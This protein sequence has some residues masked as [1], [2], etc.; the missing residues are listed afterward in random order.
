M[1]VTKLMTTRVVTVDIDS[2]LAAIKEIYDNVAF[3]HLLVVENHLLCGVIS[4][5]DVLKVLSP[6][7]GSDFATERDLACLK[8][9]AHQIMSRHLI[10]LPLH[11]DIQE[12]IHI[13]NHNGVSCIPIIDATRHPVG[14]LTWRDIMRA[15]EKKKK[16][17]VDAT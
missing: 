4:D 2:D 16:K 17:P 10:T 9:K 12:A 1:T 11:A 13:F 7:V 8:K 15:L 14:I 3:H 6:N 5:R